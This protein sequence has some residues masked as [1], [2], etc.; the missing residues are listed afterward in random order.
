VTPTMFTDDGQPTPLARTSDPDTSHAAARS[1]KARTERQEAILAAL[2]ALGGTGTDEDIADVYDGP[3]QSDSGMR[4]RRA[5]LVS[6][7]LVVDTG[8]RARIRSGNRAIVWGRV[9]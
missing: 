4:T 2:D 5:E 1:V 8:Q 6:K 7:G 3:Q 9:R